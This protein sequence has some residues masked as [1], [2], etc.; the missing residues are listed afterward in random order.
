MGKNIRKAAQG[1]AG[2]DTGGAVDALALK[3]MRRVADVCAQVHAQARCSSF[4]HSIGMPAQDLLLDVEN[5]MW[6]AWPAEFDDTDEP[7]APG[8]GPTAQ[9]WASVFVRNRLNE[10]WRRR[11]KGGMRHAPDDVTVALWDGETDQDDLDHGISEEPREIDWGR[12]GWSDP[13]RRHEFA[14]R[15]AHIIDPEGL[16][17]P[18]VTYRRACTAA[19]DILLRMTG[20]TLLDEP[21]ED[22]M[23]SAI[24]ARNTKLDT[25]RR[26]E[27]IAQVRATQGLD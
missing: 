19:R 18:E 27:V 21:D 15:I 24:W 26:E 4:A 22:A 14:T 20:R 25:R 8:E 12:S 9:T 10:E 6:C 17:D 7:F 5:A 2:R 13:S 16:Y 1:K 3:R 23:D 11:R